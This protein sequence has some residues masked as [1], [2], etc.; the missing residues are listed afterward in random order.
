MQTLCTMGVTRNITT[1]PGGIDDMKSKV[2]AFVVNAG[3]N[4]TANNLDILIKSLN[5]DQY[6][7][8]SRKSLTK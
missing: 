5:I 7:V 3:M 8:D 4:I 2:I 6:K 1:Q